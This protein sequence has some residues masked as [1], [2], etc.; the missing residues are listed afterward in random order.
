V[1]DLATVFNTSQTLIYNYAVAGATVDNNI[2]A[3]Q[4]N[5]P[6]FVQQTSTFT[7]GVAKHPSGTSWTATNSI[8][9]SFFGIN[10]LLNPFWKGSTA[11]VSQLADRY[12]QEL[13]AIYNAG[14]RNFF[15]MTVPRKQPPSTELL[16]LR[17]N[18]LHR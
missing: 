5:I 14:V 8:A 18:K 17:I 2:V 13:Q 4:G 6:S 7:S 9:G 3:A 10:D 15:V 16:T 11:P 12:F 1:G